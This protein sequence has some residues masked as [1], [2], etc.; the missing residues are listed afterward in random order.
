MALGT[1]M[2][3]AC[4]PNNSETDYNVKKKLLWKELLA[5]KMWRTRNTL[6]SFSI[7]IDHLVSTA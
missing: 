5:R 4:F 3:Q 6:G 2:V 7:N 1:R